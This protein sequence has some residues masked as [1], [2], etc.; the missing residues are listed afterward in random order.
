MTMDP[1][2]AESHTIVP[3]A[4]ITRQLYGGKASPQ[5]GFRA[6]GPKRVLFI[7]YAFPPVGGAG[8]QRVTKFVKYLPHEGWLPSVLTV[9]N[10]S[11][12]A[13]DPT[14]LKDVPDQTV[15]RRARTLEP[16]YKLKSAVS[17]GTPGKTNGG[18]KVRRF[19]AGAARRLAQMIL[20]PDPQVLWLPDAI[21]QGR[22]L[23]DEIPHAAIIASGPPFSAFLIGKAL[24]KHARIPLILDY[25]DEWDLSTAYLE[26]KSANR[27]SLLILRR[28]QKRVL[29]SA[30]A[31][32]TTTKASASAIEALRNK[33]KST[34]PVRCFYNGF[35]PD[36]FA[37]DPAVEPQN[38]FYRLVY[39]GTLWNLTS[40]EPLVQA[41]RKL[42][43]Q[44]PALVSRLELVFAGRRTPAQQHIL[45]QLKNAPCRIVEHG[46][47]GHQD[48]IQL[49]R[50][51]DTLC[52]LLTDL[53]GTGRVVPAKIFEYMAT[54]RPILA[55]SPQGELEALLSDY[56]SGRHILPGDI[57]GIA[58]Y[59]MQNL[60]NH[61]AGS[62][63]P[64]DVSDLIK[65][66][67][68]YQTNQLANFLDSVI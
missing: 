26:H 50:S 27:F 18:G 56:P 4:D 23:L 25:R 58:G 45:D 39:V 59:L 31:I 54:R 21:R 64:L 20:Q 30:R 17:D 51:A 1:S 41:V 33:S 19:I 48:A 52:A 36:D 14:L 11:V 55:I 15:I 12:P 13:F 8:V 47:I 67:R 22:R 24:A 62:H 3:R 44:E 32:L 6:A 42:A 34:A 68:P 60:R 38:E 40:V 63:A 2:I 9:A 46:Y 49:M 10:P 5:A 35:D 29:Q 7:S 57:H 37:V 61:A 53:P 16:G 43:E 65:H 66:S 28:M